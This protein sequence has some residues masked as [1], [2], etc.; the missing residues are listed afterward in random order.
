MRINP[1]RRPLRRIILPL[2]AAIFTFSSM[3]LYVLSHNQRADAISTTY[4]VTTTADSG[5]GS[6]RAA[7]TSSN[8]NTTTA[9]D[10]NKITFNIPGT[11]VQTISPVTQFPNITQ[12]T[13]IDGTTQSGSSCGTLVPSLPAISNTPH[14]LNV[15]ITQAISG[16]SI[17]TLT[18]TAAS[19]TI[20]GLIMNGPTGNAWLLTAA[21]PNATISC[22]YIGTDST[23]T[24]AGSGNTNFGGI[25]I[26]SGASNISIDNNL[27]AGLGRWGIYGGAAGMQVSHNIIGPNH[28]GNAVLMPNL[29]VGINLTGGSGLNLKQNVI[30]GGLSG[31]SVLLNQ[32]NASIVGNFM[33]V[34]L[35]G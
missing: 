22:N 12:P 6:L 5:P 16:P 2:F 30:S 25:S 4:V 11:G 15:Q 1:K 34:G 9:S 26:G 10:P 28:A 27:I 33:G 35:D 18:S 21:A 19:S 20:K 31:D 13:I 24:M 8:A 14:A 29:A 7:I 3:S 23:G 32:S 17:F